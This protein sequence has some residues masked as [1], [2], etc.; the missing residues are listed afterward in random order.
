MPILVS[1]ANIFIDLEVGGLLEEAFGLP[2]QIRTPDLIFQDELAADHPKL[3]RLGLVLG[4][5]DAAGMA[6]LMELASR[7]T[8]ISRYDAAALALARST[9]CPLVTG[10]SRLRKAARSESVA[11]HGTIWLVGRMI[12]E[13]IVTPAAA[14]SAFHAM[15]AD[16]RRLP[17]EAAERMTRRKSAS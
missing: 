10:D 2:E 9:D 11:V 8:G 3:I 14:R 4:E 12:D 17:W 7:Y 15:R 16:G 13:R 6:E 1:D 5:L